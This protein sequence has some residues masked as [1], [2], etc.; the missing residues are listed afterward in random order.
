MQALD[1]MKEKGK[2]ADVV[3]GKLSAKPVIYESS[4]K[5]GGKHGM[6]PINVCGFIV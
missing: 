6:M 3:K 1:V 5:Y 2:C 4:V